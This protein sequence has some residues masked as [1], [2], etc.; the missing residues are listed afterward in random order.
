MALDRVGLGILLAILA[1]VQAQAAS[2]GDVYGRWMPYDEKTRACVPNA[3][4]S[5]TVTRS[6][7]RIDYGGDVFFPRPPNP[8]K[9]TARQCKVPTGWPEPAATWTWTFRGKDVALVEGWIR[10]VDWP[11]VPDFQFKDVLKRGC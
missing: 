2:P 4:Y 1:T 7:L 3:D 5:V 9:C 8:P 10:D 11:E 6:E